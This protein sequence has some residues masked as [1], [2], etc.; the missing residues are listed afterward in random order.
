MKE[1][2]KE[3]KNKLYEAEGL[4]ELLQLREDKSAELLPLIKER[5][6]SITAL[7][8][9]GEM[10][11]EE[12]MTI[13]DTEEVDGEDAIYEVVDDEESEV[14]QDHAADEPK[15]APIK[16]NRPAFCLN[17]LFRFRRAL[18]G[19]NQSEFDGVLDHIAT[20]GQYEDAENYIYG[21]LGFEPDDE[22]VTDFMEIIKSYFGA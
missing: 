18:F 12:P 1:N 14:A 5:I 17:D 11:L 6:E 22:D 16:K 9:N 7:L 2:L 8:S 10:D 19:G 15:P 4:V 13:H 20:L 21:E 3:I